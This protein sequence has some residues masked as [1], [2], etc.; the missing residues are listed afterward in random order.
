MESEKKDTTENIIAG[1][2]M[3]V[4][5]EV[6][7]TAFK[8]DPQAIHALV[9]NRVP[10]NSKLASDDFVV[11][12]ENRVLGEEA[13]CVGAMGLV[14]A[15]VKSITGKIIAVQWADPE[16]GKDYG[17]MIGFC[18]YTPPKKENDLPIKEND[19]PIIF[20]RDGDKWCATYTDFINLQESP[21]GFGD[22]QE[23]AKAD[24]IKADLAY[25]TA[26]ENYADADRRATQE[27]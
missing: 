20:S 18:E 16:P 13:C 4:A 27:G 24:L 6:L 19:L 26:K 12:R 2:M 1:V 14:N 25:R 9:C 8:K 5:L 17:T 10:C 21:A 15:V 11:V 7:N 22:T 3:R 23:E